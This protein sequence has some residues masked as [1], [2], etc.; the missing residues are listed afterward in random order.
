M[1]KDS[2][3][4]AHKIID[5]FTSFMVIGANEE[6]HDIEVLS[7][8]RNKDINRFIIAFILQLVENGISYPDVLSRIERMLLYCLKNNV[9]RKDLL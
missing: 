8:L 7:F 4:K 1:K 5:N 2:Q 6:K 3:E 9:K